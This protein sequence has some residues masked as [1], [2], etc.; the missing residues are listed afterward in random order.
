MMDLLKPILLEEKFKSIPKMI[1]TQFCR[2]DSMV[3]TQVVETDG[4]CENLSDRVN[5]QE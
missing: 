3:E 2:G 1:I 4:T 5:P